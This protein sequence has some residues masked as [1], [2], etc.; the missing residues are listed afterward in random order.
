MRSIPVSECQVKRSVNSVLKNQ[1]KNPIR[2]IKKKRK[3]E[4]KE[5][6]KRKERKKTMTFWGF[7]SCDVLYLLL[8]VRSI[9]ETQLPVGGL[10]SQWVLLPLHFSEGKKK[11][12]FGKAGVRIKQEG[13]CILR[14]EGLLH[15]SLSPHQPR[16]QRECLLTAMFSEAPSII[17]RKSV[18]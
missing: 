14:E 10:H 9:S 4:K 1:E 6:K 15:H 17:D 7:F 2:V 13:R 3:Q 16:H 11:T 18:V 5:K 12:G 8:H